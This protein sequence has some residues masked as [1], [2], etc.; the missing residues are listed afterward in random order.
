MRDAVKPFET[1]FYR[2]RYKILS[3]NLQYLQIRNNRF[4]VFPRREVLDQSVEIVWPKNTCS[5]CLAILYRC[6]IRKIA[7]LC[8][9]AACI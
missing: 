6:T 2:R 1:H 7:E 3:Q 9:G 8:M 4:V 5:N